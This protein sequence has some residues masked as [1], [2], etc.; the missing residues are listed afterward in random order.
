M[1]E[2]RKRAQTLD[3]ERE[4]ET[5]EEYSYGGRAQDE[6]TGDSGGRPLYREG[7]EKR[8]ADHTSLNDP[9]FCTE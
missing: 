3:R 1:G 4:T 7:P 6:E 9:E 5:E 2:G 8:H